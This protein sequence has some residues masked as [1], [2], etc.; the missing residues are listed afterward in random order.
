MSDKP[1]QKSWLEE[2]GLRLIVIAVVFGGLMELRDE[3]H[4]VWLRM[5][6]AAVA[7]GFIGLIFHRR[8]DV[9]D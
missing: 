8:H 4:S 9:R 6:L 2:N 3:M 1:K 5:L 7:G